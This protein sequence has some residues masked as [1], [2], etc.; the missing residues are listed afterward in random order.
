MLQMRQS[1]R[2][3]YEILEIYMYPGMST[4]CQLREPSTPWSR[5]VKWHLGNDSNHKQTRETSR[6]NAAGGAHAI[7]SKA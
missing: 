6:D 4:G 2:V 7:F 3:L 5:T 1:Y